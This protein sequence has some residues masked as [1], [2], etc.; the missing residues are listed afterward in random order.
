RRT[1]G[2]VLQAIWR[3]AQLFA[4]LHARIRQD[5][6]RVCARQVDGNTGEGSEH[7]P[8]V[9]ATLTEALRDVVDRHQARYLTGAED[10]ER[11]HV[12]TGSGVE[13]RRISERT[14]LLV[15]EHEDRQQG[16]LPREPRLPLKGADRRAELLFKATAV[17]TR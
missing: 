12:P 15:G 7:E 3:R 11:P 14:V 8:P 1:Q 16:F 2:E 10:V 9:V 17:N 4:V 6:G 5:L 13:R